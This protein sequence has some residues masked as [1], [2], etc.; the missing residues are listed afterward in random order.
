M[1]FK[2]LDGV[3]VVE[4]NSQRFLLMQAQLFAS[5]VPK[6]ATIGWYFRRCDAIED[7][8]A[9]GGKYGEHFRHD[10]LEMTTVS[11]NKDGIGS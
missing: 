1:S 3:V 5:L 10:F 11:A 8:D 7:D 9:I 4:L 2:Y 6:L